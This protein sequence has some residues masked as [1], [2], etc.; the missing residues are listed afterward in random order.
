M[1]IQ[2]SELDK[3]QLAALD[4]LCV[5]CKKT[6]GN[7]VAIY[8]H[9][10]GKNR[11]RPSNI[12][13]YDQQT[14]VGV[15]GAFFFYQHT[16][17][18]ALLVAPEFR[19]Q[20]IAARMLDAIAPLLETE[21]VKKLVFSSP[22]GLNDPWLLGAGLC[23][24]GSEFQMQRHLS[25]PLPTLSS[26]TLIRLAN[27][28]DISDLCAI[29]SACFPTQNIDMPHRFHMLLN[30]ADNCLF[31]IKQNLVTVGKAHLCWQATGA[32]LSDIAILPEAQGHGLGTALLT[33]CINHALAVNQP[34]I[35]LD[36]ETTNKQALGLYTRLG[37][38][39]NN[40]HDYWTHDKI[41][42]TAFLHHL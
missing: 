23:Y 30:S 24:E 19:R 21:G 17:E 5:T 35:T 31:I 41:G 10:L 34:D 11:G 16:C 9:L 39:V 6:D 8:R 36:V 7:Q 15:L 42:L 38:T 28:H 18:I 37:F 40:A 13:F 1:L 33:H 22:H 12:L 27:L 2:T 20:G 25:E 32:R 4:L 26:S 14:L 29:D 3:H